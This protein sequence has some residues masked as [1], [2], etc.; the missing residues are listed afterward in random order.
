MS[1][2][3]SIPWHWPSLPEQPTAFVPPPGAKGMA[4]IAPEKRREIAAKG[5]AA[6]K[7]KRQGHKFTSE[8]AR[9]AGLRTA[10]RRAERLQKEGS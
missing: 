4:R 3:P 5:G 10:Q 2:C 9:A 6:T 1:N 7:G 8:E